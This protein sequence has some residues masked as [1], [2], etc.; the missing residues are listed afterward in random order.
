MANLQTD[1]QTDDGQQ[2]IRKAHL[3][4]QFGWAKTGVQYVYYMEFFGN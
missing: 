3:T 4:F 1:G 2:A